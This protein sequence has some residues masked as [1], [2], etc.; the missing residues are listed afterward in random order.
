LRSEVVTAAAVAAETA[1][2]TA[3]GVEILAAGPASVGNPA[4]APVSGG[5]VPALVAV[6]PALEENPADVPVL[7]GVARVSAVARPVEVLTRLK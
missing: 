5:D 7:A 1:G 2:E 3:A 4:V 6:G